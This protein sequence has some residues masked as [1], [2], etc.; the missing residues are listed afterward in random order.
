MI[1]NLKKIYE[2]DQYVYQTFEFFKG[3][4]L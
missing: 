2:D 1:P 3:D 4:D